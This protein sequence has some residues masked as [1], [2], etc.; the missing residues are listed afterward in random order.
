[1]SAYRIN[2]SVFRWNSILIGCLLWQ[3]SPAF[4]PY[5]G[6]ATPSELRDAIGTLVQERE[7]G[8]LD[9]KEEPK[10]VSSCDNSAET[11]GLRTHVWLAEQAV[12]AFER[13]FPALE[14]TET[15]KINLMYGVA[16]ED[17]D[18]VLSAR[19]NPLFPS[20]IRFPSDP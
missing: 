10:L 13:S 1:M 11:L 3:I 7:S 12:A 5:S 2:S 16:E 19:F 4:S 18:T 14:L 15:E 17:I 6:S 8:N 20:A 9:A